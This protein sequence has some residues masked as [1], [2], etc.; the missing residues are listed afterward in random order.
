[1]TRTVIAVALASVTMLAQQKAPQFRSRTDGVPLN[2]SVFQGDRVVTNLKASDFEIID[3]GVR[4]TVA[5]A[6]FDRLPL[7]LRL[8]FDTSGSISDEELKR[9]EGMMRRVA[10]DLEPTDRGEIITFN[11]KLAEAADR[12]HPPLVVNLKRAG[13]DGTAFFD[14]G[15]AVMTTVGM[16]DRRQMTILLSDAVDNESF[17]DEE[18]LF[19]A[20]RRT[21]SVVYS[22]LPGNS[23]RG[24]AL[25]E[26]RLDY[27]STV[28]GG[29][30]IKTVPSDVANTITRTIGEFRQSYLLQY[31]VTGVPV[32]GWHKVEVK[33]KGG[34]YK[35]RTRKGY[36]GK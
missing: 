2:V 20:A 4:Q 26:Q 24:R 18:M 13:L 19:E 8:V 12:R 27:L 35:I 28:T 30:L 25:S 23:L 33:V 9:Y 5:S 32:P 17:F 11:T 34:G 3:N 15:L 29:R 21:D 36:Y 6:D 10:E 22:V 16:S 7:D 14:A 31:D 1:M